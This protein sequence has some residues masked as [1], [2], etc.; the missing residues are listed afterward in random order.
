VYAER[1]GPD[2]EELEATLR[3]R[4][5]NRPQEDQAKQSQAMAEFFQKAIMK[6]NGD[7]D[8]A[9]NEVLKA[10]KT[11]SA[12]ETTRRALNKTSS[13]EPVTQTN[14]AESTANPSA[15][16]KKSVANSN[17]STGDDRVL[18][19]ASENA[20]KPKKKKKK[21]AVAEVETESFTND[22]TTKPLLSETSK[23]ALLVTSVAVLAAGVGYM[24]GGK[25]Q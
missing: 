11:S 7:V 20:M 8:K 6:P 18:Q 14:A 19:A 5:G 3:E 16:V 1:F 15:E 2:K 22:T 21:K 17:Q 24:A 25:R 23:S 12:Q 13:I 9:L 10:G 4:Y